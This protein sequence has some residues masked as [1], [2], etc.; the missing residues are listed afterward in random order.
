VCREGQDPP[1]SQLP[2]SVS[3]TGASI[4][5]LLAL[6]N[7]FFPDK[8]FLVRV[9]QGEK[10]QTMVETCSKRG[11]FATIYTGHESDFLKTSEF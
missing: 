8:F 6:V 5:L 11:T 4:V 10:K 3:W 1:Q 9:E 2:E 7:F